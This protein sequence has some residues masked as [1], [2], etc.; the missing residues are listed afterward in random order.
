MMEWSFK[1]HPRRF[2]KGYY[3]MVV[4]PLINGYEYTKCLMDKRRTLDIMYV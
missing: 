4:N 3:I 1:D 2:S